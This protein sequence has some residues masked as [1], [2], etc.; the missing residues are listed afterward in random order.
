MNVFSSEGTTVTDDTNTIFG[1]LGYPSQQSNTPG[2]N[3]FVGSL[4]PLAFIPSSSNVPSTT[5]PNGT[6]L[7]PQTIPDFSG[8]GLSLMS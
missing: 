7:V 8:L 3:N 6:G 5:A 2:G 4:L 1:L